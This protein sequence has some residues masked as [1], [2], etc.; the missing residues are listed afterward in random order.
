M[1][2]AAA[3]IETLAVTLLKIRFNEI[4][5]VE[6]ASFTYLTGYALKFV[7][8]S[9]AALALCF[10]LVSPILPF[11]ALTRLQLSIAYPV[12][13]ALHLSFM[14]AFTAALLQEPLTGNKLTALGFI[15]LSLVFFFW[16]QSKG[17]TPQS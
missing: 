11:I 9:P 1:L 16:D 14:L 6:S 12:M 10:I 13:V 3:F 17:E 2:V 4:G 8:S 5:G 15:L 7:E